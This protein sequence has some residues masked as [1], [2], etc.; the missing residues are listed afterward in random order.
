[1]LFKVNPVISQT[2]AVKGPALT[3]QAARNFHRG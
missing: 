3:L 1:M 2:E